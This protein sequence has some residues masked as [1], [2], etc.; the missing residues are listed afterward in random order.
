[1]AGTFL[2]LWLEGAQTDSCWQCK[3]KPMGPISSKPLWTTIWKMKEKLL[4]LTAQLEPCFSNSGPWASCTI[5]AQ[6]LVRNAQ[7]AQ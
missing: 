2:L 7:S 1:M 3:M 5:L 4:L 6:E